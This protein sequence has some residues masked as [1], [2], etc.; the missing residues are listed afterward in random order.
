MKLALE[1]Y[2]EDSEQFSCA[3]FST[4]AL[5]SVLRPRSWPS[6]SVLDAFLALLKSDSVKVIGMSFSYNLMMK[7]TAET[8]ERCKT[9]FLGDVSPD[10]VIVPLVDSF[11]GHFAL[12]VL[13][14]DG[15][16]I[17]YDTKLYRR[18]FLP[19]FGKLLVWAKR[20][21]NYYGT[22]WTVGNS[23]YETYAVAKEN[24]E[25]IDTSLH[26]CYHA[27][28]VAAKSIDNYSCCDSPK[29]MR[30]VLTRCIVEE[31]VESSGP[32][33]QVKTSLNAMSRRHALTILLRLPEAIQMTA[34]MCA[35]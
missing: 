20:L 18:P 13:Q 3:R 16:I 26:M 6:D 24:V 9:N 32:F 35:F 14:R 34:S 22:S 2:S 12:A 23:I 7:K 15:K 11:T 10:N 30:E 8:F 17:V 25:E 5:N 27:Y 4:V 21:Q 31:R 29:V 33:F 1:N 28:N 19:L